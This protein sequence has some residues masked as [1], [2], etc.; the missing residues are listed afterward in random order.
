VTI[1]IY[2]IQINYIYVYYVF[3]YIC[4]QYNLQVVAID[5]EDPWADKL[6]DIDDVQRQIP[7]MSAASKACQQLV[8]QRSLSI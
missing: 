1:D 3:I 5:R 8:K 7:G 2:I 4:I 6:K